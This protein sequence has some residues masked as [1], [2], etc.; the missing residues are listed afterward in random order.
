MQSLE[1]TSPVN[2]TLFSAKPAYD[3]IKRTASS[4]YVFVAVRAS[5]DSMELTI[6]NNP[7]ISTLHSP[8][9]HWSVKEVLRNAWLDIND[10]N[11]DILNLTVP[12][13]IK[14]IKCVWVDIIDMLSVNIAIKEPVIWHDWFNHSSYNMIERYFNAESNVEY[15]AHYNDNNNLLSIHDSWNMA[16]ALNYFDSKADKYVMKKTDVYCAEGAV[17]N[18]YVRADASSNNKYQHEVGTH[19]L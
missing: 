8:V 14:N 19:N 11:V 1:L 3:K 12:D 17:F 13:G 2:N 18:Y 16:G 9:Y 15:R 7:A 6:S 5:G 10:T 4:R